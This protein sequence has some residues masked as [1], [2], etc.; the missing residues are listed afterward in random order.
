MDVCFPFKHSERVLLFLAGVGR[1]WTLAGRSRTNLYGLVD[2]NNPKQ[3]NGHK[4]SFLLA[5]VERRVQTEVA[6]L[7]AD[8]NS[9]SS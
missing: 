4:N 6:F 7:L 9:S 1:T 2:T 3:T 8:C 5:Y